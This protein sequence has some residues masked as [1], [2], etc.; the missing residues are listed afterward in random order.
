[1]A[2]IPSPTTTLCSSDRCGG[3]LVLRGA[4]VLSYPIPFKMSRLPLLF[5][6]LD[7]SHEN[8]F[9]VSKSETA[10]RLIQLQL[11]EVLYFKTHQDDAVSLTQTNA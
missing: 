5:N 11:T 9:N 1:M 8:A 6:P 2:E 3:P 10:L 7:R 4:F